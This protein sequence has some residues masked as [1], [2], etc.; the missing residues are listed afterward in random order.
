MVH[1]RQPHEVIHLLLLEC[2]LEGNYRTL[3]FYNYSSQVAQ[4]F[5]PPSCFHFPCGAECL[6]PITEMRV[7]HMVQLL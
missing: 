5:F 4:Q 7:G 6:V 1:H 2:W 3:E